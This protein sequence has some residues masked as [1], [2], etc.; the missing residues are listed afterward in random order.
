MQLIIIMHHNY[1][2]IIQ[3]SQTNLI[4]GLFEKDYEIA[5]CLTYYVNVWALN[6]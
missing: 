5:L 4:K 3:N 2:C 1:H 6:Y